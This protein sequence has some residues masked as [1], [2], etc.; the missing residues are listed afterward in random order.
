M[1][2][3]SYL[4]WNH[5]LRLFLIARDSNKSDVFGFEE[6]SD[7]SPAQDKTRRKVRNRT[8]ASAACKRKIRQKT[9]VLPFYTTNIKTIR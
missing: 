6:S 9:T 4:Q 1:G 8:E 7:V 5:I 3:I 2:I